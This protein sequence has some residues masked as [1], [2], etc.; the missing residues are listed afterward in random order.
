[1]DMKKIGRFIAKKKNLCLITALI[2]TFICIAAIIF[3][4]AIL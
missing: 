1:M 3:L 2:L 4:V